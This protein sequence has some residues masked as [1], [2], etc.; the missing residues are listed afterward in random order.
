MILKPSMIVSTEHFCFDLLSFYYAVQ[1][2][3]FLALKMLLLLIL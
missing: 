1:L 2:T 3:R